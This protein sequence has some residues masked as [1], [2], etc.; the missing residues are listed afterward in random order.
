MGTEVAAPTS[1]GVWWGIG[2]GARMQSD[3]TVLVASSSSLTLL[4][5]LGRSWIPT[6]YPAE[7]PVLKALDEEVGGTPGL[8][9]PL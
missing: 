3:V 5:G 8:A 7:L 1:V 6:S 4:G 2:W 9:G